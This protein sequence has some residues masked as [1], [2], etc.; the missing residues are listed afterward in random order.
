MPLAR[1][2][3]D[4]GR[5]L[6]KPQHAF[7]SALELAWY[8]SLDAAFKL[9]PDGDA[10]RVAWLNVDRF[11]TQWV[12]AV[13]SASLGYILGN[14]V[15]AEVF[16][17]YLALPSP[18][19]APLVGQRIGGYRD[20]LDPHGVKLTTFSL[21]GDG[22]RKRH[23]AVKHLLDRDIQ[24]HGV[25]CSCEVFGLFAPLLPQAARATV[26]A[27]SLR[28]RQGLVPDFK[29]ARPDGLE[30]LMELKLI[31]GP[32][33]YA[34]GDLSRCAAVAR[35]ARAIPG[36]YAA[37]ARE[38]DQVCGADPGAAESGPVTRKLLSF[39]RI[40]C[41][42]FGAFGEASEDMHRLV[43][44]LAGGRASRELVRMGC[45]DPNAAK[46][47]L[48]RYLC[49]SWG[50]MALRAQAGL[51]L[52]GMWALVPLLRRRDAHL[53]RTSTVAPVK[54]ISCTIVAGVLSVPDVWPGCDS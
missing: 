4:E 49:R 22:W 5:A 39:G 14:D 38:L 45:R 3:T 20:V 31:A 50:I 7:T 27:F 28:K 44:L 42:V 8:D 2:G 36:E 9:L 35:R 25:Q 15:F 6:H 21:P 12:G 1:A 43:D 40:Q 19:C 47:G 54:R 41:L 11:S 34:H 30:V 53:A 46:A 33:W 24:A 16:A 10:A 13:P 23:D 29:V 18:A 51:K 37:K 48:A 32:T 17:A 26:R 52:G